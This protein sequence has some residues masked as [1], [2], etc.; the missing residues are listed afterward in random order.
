[1]KNVTPSPPA[2]LT[3]GL[4]GH[5]LQA[6]YDDVRQDPLLGP[7]FERAI[8]PSAWPEH[9]ARMQD[10]WSS[11]AL[12][13]HAFRGNVMDKHTTLPGLTPAMF[14]RWLALWRLHTEAL[15]QPAVATQMQKVARGVA[16]NLHYVLFG[17]FPDYAPAYRPLPQEARHG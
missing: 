11:V 15:L 1:M 3:P 2:P 5:L 10:F 8:A 7:V 12:R 16:R 13:S 17:Q 4:L 6:F 9:L 14:E